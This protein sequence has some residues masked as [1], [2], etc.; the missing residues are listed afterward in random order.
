MKFKLPPILL[1]KRTK[2]QNSTKHYSA[3]LLIWQFL[4]T[5]YL[6]D[7]TI[8]S[9]SGPQS[10]GISQFLGSFLDQF[11]PILII[12]CCI[13]S[14]WIC[15]T[16]N[17]TSSKKSTK[18]MKSKIEA[19]LTLLKYL[20]PLIVVSI[21]LF[22]SSTLQVQNQSIFITVGTITIVTI[23][24]V[25]TSLKSLIRLQQLI[26]SKPRNIFLNIKSDATRRV[27]FIILGAISSR[28]IGLI[29]LGS[30]LLQRIPQ[31]YFILLELISLILLFS[32]KPK[33]SFFTNTCPTCRA[34]RS[35]IFENFPKCPGCYPRV[36]Y[37]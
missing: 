1:H 29:A 26:L 28:I 25:A 8:I 32:C 3:A 9:L 10:I 7:A 12:V 22:I 14:I 35:I 20:I 31:T 16:I 27:S 2:V 13:L 30:Y 37:N 36:F 17:K 33:L 21:L 34:T 15:V 11:S 6:I 18:N 5:C 4:L 19:N 23:A 24:L